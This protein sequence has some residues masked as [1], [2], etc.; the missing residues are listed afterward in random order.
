MDDFVHKKQKARL[1]WGLFCI[2]WNYPS[3]AVARSPGE[4]GN[5]LSGTMTGA[6]LKMQARTA[7]I[8]APESS[9][10]K[11]PNCVNWNIM[12]PLS[13][14]S[15]LR[16]STS[17]WLYATTPVSSILK[18][19]AMKQIPKP[20]NTFFMMFPSFFLCLY[21]QS[22]LRVRWTF[23]YLFWISES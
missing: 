23:C 16:F 3:L 18:A 21:G 17:R 2:M 8:I 22:L 9:R 7:R 12:R 11:P 10:K 4:T 14:A 19:S 6:G 15:L 13:I 5:L 20:S 1:A